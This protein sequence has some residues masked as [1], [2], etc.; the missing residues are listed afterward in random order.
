MNIEQLTPA[1]RFINIL[2]LCAIIL[3]CLSGVVM[4]YGSWM[5]WLYNLHRSTGISLVALIPL[6]AI[7]VYRSAARGIV[8]TFKQ[9]I[10]LLNSSILSAL[11]LL[12]IALGAMWMWRLG[13]YSNSQTN[14]TSLVLGFWGANHALLCSPHLAALATSQK[15]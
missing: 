8:K 10:A 11:T 4:L 2:L 6:K 3:L 5:P 7:T 14:L 15:S 12:I 1:D 9:R 13:P